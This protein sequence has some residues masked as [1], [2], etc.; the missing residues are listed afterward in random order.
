MTVYLCGK[1]SNLSFNEMNTWR[2]VAK[3]YLENNNVKAINPVTFYNTVTTDPS[4]Y[5]EHEVMEFDLQAVRHSDVLLVNENENS[6][7]TA[8]EMHEA[9]LHH[10]PIVAFSINKNLHPWIKLMNDVECKNMQEAIFYILTYY[11]PIMK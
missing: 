4:T 2:K 10:I 9:K 11:Q 1:M 3:Q 6:I 8:I 5:S 7:G